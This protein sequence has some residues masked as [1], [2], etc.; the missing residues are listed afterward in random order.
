MKIAIAK[1]LLI[2]IALLIGFLAVK[3]AFANLSYLKLN[4]Y[5]TRWE[6]SKVLTQA[7][8]DDAFSAS[9]SMLNLH[10][11]HPHYLNMAAKLYEWK[12]FKFNDDKSIYFH[13]LEQALVLYKKST[14]LRPHWPLTWA[15]MA[16]VKAKLGM[17]DK[18][19]YYYIDQSIKYGPYMPEVNLQ[20]SKLFLA[21]WGTLA[22]FSTKVGL[23][24]VNRALLIDKA[25]YPLINYAHSI[26]KE[27]LVC[28]VGRLKKIDSVNQHWL[29]KQ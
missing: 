15:H 27:Q 22:G 25:L 24:Q 11:H 4:T 1:T 12:A 7:E 29:C 26:G 9:E 16:N 28:T 21:H 20:V 19:F 14:I 17:I 23:E 18:D 3:Y 13:S 5:L 2:S 8:L 6:Q 10:G